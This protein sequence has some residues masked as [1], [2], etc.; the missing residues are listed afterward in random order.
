[1]TNTA[2]PSAPQHK[3]RNIGVILF[4]LAIGMVGAAYAAVPLYYAFCAATGYGGTTREA[5]AAP[6]GAIARQMTINFDAD[7]DSSIPWQFIAA[8][9][10]TDKIGNADT[11]MFSARNLSDKPVT[12]QA[13]YNVTPDLAG[14]YFYKIQC[15]C[16]SKQT[17]KPGESVQMPV[18]FY[19]DPAID[20]DPDLRT[21]KTITLHYTFYAAKE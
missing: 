17:L 12:G 7:V 3:N 9:P 6:L 1:M 2:L 19:V 11:V 4:V 16:F 18:T 13:V 20:K 15:F 21:I 14:Q 5:T 8:K 10:V